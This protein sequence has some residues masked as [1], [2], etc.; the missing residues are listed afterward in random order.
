MEEKLPS[1]KVTPDNLGDFLG[2]PKF[3]HARASYNAVG[4]AMADSIEQA[5]D[6][7]PV[8]ADVRVPSRL[9]L[10]LAALDWTRLEYDDG[11]WETGAAGFGYG[12]GDD[13]T[14]LIDMED[15]YSSVYLRK[16]FEVADPARA[17]ALR[18]CVPTCTTR[19]ISWRMPI[20]TN[21]STA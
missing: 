5:A 17:A 20:C 14:V 16:R 3:L 6:H 1:V 15:R 9:S 12:D 19:R 13:A 8:F 7:I 2:V 11:A 10:P 4:I 21:K 18:L